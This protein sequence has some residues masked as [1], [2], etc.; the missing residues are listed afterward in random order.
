[1]KQRIMFICDYAAPYGGNFIAS[2]LELEKELESKGYECIYIFTIRSE[3]RAW[4]N[5]II[6]LGKIVK[7]YDLDNVKDYFAICNVVKK[8]NVKIAHLHF[9]RISLAIFLKYFS[10]AQMVVWHI[11]SDFSLG[12]NK[13]NIKLWIRYSICGKY[14]KIVSVSK[15]IS[16][17]MKNVMYLPNGIAATRFDNRIVERRE[18]RTK[19]GLTDNDIMILAFGWSPKVK[20]VDIAV[21]VLNRL[22]KEDKRYKL[23]L[24]CG[25]DYTVDKMKQ[26]IEEDLQQSLRN[27]CLLNPIENVF[28]YHKCSDILLSASRSEGF[29]YTILEALCIGNKCVVSDIP[30]IA[31]AKK[32]ALVKTFETENIGACAEC[33]KSTEKIMVDQLKVAKQVNADFSIDKWTKEIIEKIYEL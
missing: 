12:L 33:I 18:E 11:H 22:I 31:W 8:Y 21:K 4:I 2:L 3:K 16:D 5:K 32:Y 17:E 10:A 13:K 20:G 7:F 25:N 26:Y 15:K 23:Y 28:L 24:V 1:M 6:E 9:A 27:I 14:I 19:L 30:G 29:S